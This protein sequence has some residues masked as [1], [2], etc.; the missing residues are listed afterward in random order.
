MNG[1]QRRKP[2][3]SGNRKAHLETVFEFI[4]KERRCFFRL[5][6]DRKKVIAT[7]EAIWA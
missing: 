2:A 5:T 3:L 6:K 1:A 4:L 7:E